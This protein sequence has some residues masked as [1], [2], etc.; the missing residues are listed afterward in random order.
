MATTTTGSAAASKVS[1]LL[2]DL[3]NTLN[4]LG[5]IDWAD[6]MSDDQHPGAAVER[7]TSLVGLSGMLGSIAIAA[8]EP[9]AAFMDGLTSVLAEAGD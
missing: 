5:D 4:D 1:H 8:N 2:A 7:V 3:T 9:V 6:V